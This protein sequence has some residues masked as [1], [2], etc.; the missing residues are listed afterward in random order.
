MEISV[1]QGET[2]SNVIGLEVDSDEVIFTTGSGKQFKLY[3][4]Q[5]CCEHVRIEDLEGDS[6]DLEGGL[7]LNAEEVSGWYEDCD[8]PDTCDD[9]FTWTFYKIDTTK[10]GVWIRWLGESNGYYS[11]SVDF[12][13]IK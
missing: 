9:S 12:V 10:G 13:Q 5:D 11:E 4:E 7:V 8:D 6:S 1:L 3:H 2:I